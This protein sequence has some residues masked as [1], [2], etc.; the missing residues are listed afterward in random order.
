MDKAH[1]KIQWK[2]GDTYR[3]IYTLTVYNSCFIPAHMHFTLNPT[4]VLIYRNVK[5]HI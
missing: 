4:E 1:K 3:Q 5:Q 2:L